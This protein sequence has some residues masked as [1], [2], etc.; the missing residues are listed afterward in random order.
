M[1]ISY[2]AEVDALYIELRACGPGQVES[3]ELGP[4]LVADYGPDGALA[5]IEVLDASHVLGHSPDQVLIELAPQKRAAV[6]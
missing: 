5:G 6:A 3:R 1:K 4:G 2:D